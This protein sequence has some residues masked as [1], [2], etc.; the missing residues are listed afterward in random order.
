MKTSNLI[1]VISSRAINLLVLLIFAIAITG[2]KNICKLSTEKTASTYY[3]NPN[4]KPGDV[5]RVVFVELANQTPYP[6]ISRDISEGF[7]K[8]M[9]QRQLFTITFVKL[10]DPVYKTL[11]LDV[12]GM[13]TLEQLAQVHKS[14]GCDAILLGTVN[15]YQPFPHMSMGLQLRLVDLETGQLIWA[16]D[17]A[18]DAADQS[19]KK[20]IKEFYKTQSD[21]GSKDIGEQI[22]TLSPL[23]FVK[24]IAHE[25]TSTMK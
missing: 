22:V 25:V 16:M 24:F 18:W 20:R 11:Q 21:S 19:T 23:M 15:G 13:Y 3:I 7:F 8:E 14:L 6:E 10:A 4:Y 2:C 9:Q 5:G 12:Q 17:E 1:A